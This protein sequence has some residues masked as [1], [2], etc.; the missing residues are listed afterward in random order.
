MTNDSPYHA[1]ELAVQARAIEAGQAAMSDRAIADYIPD[2][3]ISFIQQQAMVVIGSM[4]TQGQIWSSVI[5]GQPGFIHAT[6][7]RTLDLDLLQASISADDPLWSNLNINTSVGLLF[8]DLGSRRRLRVNGQIHKIDTQHYVINVEQAY[9]NCPKYIQ[10]RHMIMAHTRINQNQIEASYG[11]ELNWNQKRLIAN[12]D[13]FFVASAHPEH[14]VDASHRGGQPGFIAVLNSTLL[15]IPDYSGNN[16]FNTLGNFHCYP[17]AG[18]VFMDF[19]DNRLLQLT[20]R[21]KILWKNNHLS[22]AMTGIK[23]HWQFEIIAW[24]ESP[25]SFDVSWEFLDYSTFNPPPINHAIR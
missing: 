19:T 10:R 16:M 1:G 17:Y 13:T 15:R 24:R 12:A 14:G 21:S 8:I 4:D 7:E 23:R 2:S 20:G 6:D 18:L 25:I 11:T 5:F 3:A 22:Q 9:P